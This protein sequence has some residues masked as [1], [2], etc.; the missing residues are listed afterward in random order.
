[1][2]KKI[3][4]C[5]ISKVEIGPNGNLCFFDDN[6]HVISCM[7]CSD[8]KNKVYELNDGKLVITDNNNLIFE[9]HDNVNQLIDNTE[10]NISDW[11]EKAIYTC[12]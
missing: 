8:E 5:K 1:M 12:A 9:I 11:L 2:I 4:N 10:F 7:I 3:D 6:D